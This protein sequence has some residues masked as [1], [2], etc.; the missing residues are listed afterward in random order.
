MKIK[1]HVIVSKLGLSK[2]GI[3]ELIKEQPITCAAHH[4]RSLTLHRGKVH[5]IHIKYIF[6]LIL[7]LVV[8]VLIIYI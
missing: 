1:G 4:V 8:Y 3:E 6:F 7:K 5:Q 2:E